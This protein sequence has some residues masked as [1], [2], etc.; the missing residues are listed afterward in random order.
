MIRC[1]HCHGPLERTGTGFSCHSCQKTYLNRDGI[2][3]FHDNSA[4]KEFSFPRD[5]FDLLSRTEVRSFWF[6][7][8][9]RIIGE[10]LREHMPKDSRILEVGSGTGFVAMY[11]KEQGYRIECADLFLDGLKYCKK[12]GS[13]YAY[14]Q[15]NLSDAVFQEEFDGVL[16]FDVIEHIEDD[17]TVLVN[18]HSSL[19][20]GGLL[21]LT[22]PAC[23]GIWSAMDEYAG[24]K[25][26]YS[27][28]EL[29]E[30]LEKAGFHVVRISYFMMLL[31][32]VVALPLNIIRVKKF[33][34]EERGEVMR[35]RVTDEL[36]IPPLLDSL[37]ERIFALEVPTIGYMD[38]PIGSSLIAVARKERSS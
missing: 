31:F 27:R 17:Q 29:K 23:R 21:V 37:F 19:R 4:E 36:A 25:R 24:H 35:S 20:P 26:R 3:C 15:Y 30:K 33:R 28:G 11:L 10:I 8:R 12:R 6:R 9:N 32:S 1:L 22:V 16:A 7:V 13:G 34:N 5:G 38:L 18:L 2:I 14:Y